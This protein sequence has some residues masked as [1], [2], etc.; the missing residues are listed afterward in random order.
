MFFTVAVWALAAGFLAWSWRR[1]RAKTRRALAKALKSFDNILPDFA[2]ILLL[3]G[4]SLSLLS[5]KTISI[6][7]GGQTGFWG[8]LLTSLIGAITLI[9]GFIAFPLAKSLMDLGAG[10]RQIAVFISTLTMVGVITAPM[11]M[12]YFGK[13][14]TLIRNIL[15]YAFSFI[16]ALVVGVVAGR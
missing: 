16:T 4:L 10:V 13:K 7:I 6:L 12:K 8:M 9:P 14:A 2:G 3:I 15:G 1:D 5:P 11:E